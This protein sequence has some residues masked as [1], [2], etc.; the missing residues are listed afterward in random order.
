MDP[1]KEQIETETFLSRAIQIAE[2]VDYPEGAVM[3][4]TLIDKKSGA[5]TLFACAA[6]QGLSEHTTPFDALGQ[7]S[8]G[9]AEIVISGKSLRVTRDELD[10]HAGA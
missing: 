3:S 9:E 2:L 10:D 7:I 1:D 4:R 8:D 5:V 6:G